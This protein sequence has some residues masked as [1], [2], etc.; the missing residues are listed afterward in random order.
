MLWSN[1]SKTEPRVTG[2]Y[3]DPRP[4][5]RIHEGTDFDGF[6]QVH[7][8]T[9]GTVTWAG[10]FNDAAGYAVVY[11]GPDPANPGTNMEYRHFHIDANNIRVAKG[12]RV[13]AG[14]V[15]GNMGKTGNATGLCDHLEIR[16][17]RGGQT[18]NSETF[19]RDRINSGVAA[20]AFPLPSGSYF[21]PEGGPS[22]SVSGWHSH[23][24]DLR[25][26]QQRMKD[27]GWTITVDG[28]YGPKGATTPQ[29]ETASVALAF[30]KEKGLTADSLIGPQTWAA[31]WTAPIT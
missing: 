3:G 31:A 25:V 28:L 10:F 27:R 15:L 2:R 13:T 30:Q 6:P 23:N 20:P 8:V 5:G 4:N 12:Q 29:G 26:W 24:A 9:D 11:E 21:G 22:Q 16:I 17:G 18:V 1:G 7:A 19:V 14:T